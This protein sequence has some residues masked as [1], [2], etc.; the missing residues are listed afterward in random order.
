MALIDDVYGMTYNSAKEQMS[1]LNQAIIQQG[2]RGFESAEELKQWAH[3]HQL[4]KVVLSNMNHNFMCISHK[5][6]L[7]QGTAFDAYYGSILYYEQRDGNKMRRVQWHPEGFEYFDKAYIIGE[8]SDGIHKPLYYRNYCVPTGYYSPEHDAFNVAKPFPVYAKETGRD[9]SHIYTY[10]DHVAGEC[11]MW[12]LAWLRAKMLYPNVKTQV[13]PI[14]VSRAQGSGKTTFAEVIC[15]GLFGKDNVLVTDQYDSGARFNAD[16]ADALIVCQEEKEETDKRNP[17]GALKSRATATTIRKE[18]KG[19]DPIYQ[20]SYTDF[21]MT[22]NKDVPI[23]FDGREDQRRFM[24]MEADEHFTRKESALA[25]EVFT[26]LY[27]FDAEY[28][29]VG[30]PFQDD[31]DLIAQFKHELFTRADIAAVKLRQFP[32]TAAYNRCFTLPR[33]S[34]ATEIE[35]I[36]RALAPFIKASLEQNKVVTAV[37]D[38]KLLDI[39][40]YEGAVQYVPAYKEHTKF[41]ALCRPLVFYEMA[42][43]KPF[44]HSVVERSIYDCSPWLLSDYGLAVIPDMDPLLGGFTAVAGRYRTAPAA[45]ICLASDLHRNPAGYIQHVTPVTTNVSRERIGE[46]LRIDRNWKVNDMGCYETVNEMKPGTRSLKDKTQHVQYMDTFLFESDDA[47]AIQVA[48]EKKRAAE[49]TD[50]YGEGSTIKADVLYKERLHTS[51]TEGMKLFDKGIV[52]R[53]V[54]SGAK[55]YHFMVRVSDPPTT[56]EE[57][58]W[59]H[60]YLCTTL[61]DKLVFDESTADPARLTRSPLTMAR[62]SSAYGLLVEGEQKLV[63][64]DWSH[65]YTIGWREL[66]TQWCNRPLSKYEQKNGRPLIPTRPE[67]KEAMEA[68]LDKSFWTDEKWDGR[69]QVCFFA[70]YRLLRYLGY[71]HAELWDGGIMMAGIDSYKKRSEITYW[72]TRG[73]SSLVEKIDEDIDNYEASLEEAE[74]DE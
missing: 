54:Y 9:T 20:E 63:A 57:Y 5:G 35:S 21:I 38:A 69:R 41:I 30:L 1:L 49:W 18:Q 74:T 65:V 23:K 3:D 33:T 42:T 4:D 56:V 53:I 25:D 28:N 46:R 67:Y 71:S 68:V 11:A 39:I 16:Y 15:K 44:T 24:I 29:R 64:E 31:A 58:N 60:A 34:E 8:Q 62:I 47:T 72:K 50:K 27:G 22:T 43:N 59:L 40:Q 45:K 52:A 19:V 26:K 73:K 55:S 12:L 13:V 51:L 61:T 32:K 48:Q 66:Y 7:L 37:D 36:L 17:A 2:S 70:A 14:I 10:I 6:E